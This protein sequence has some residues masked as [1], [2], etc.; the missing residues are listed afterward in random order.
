MSAKTSNEALD[1]P[2]RAVVEY[3]TMNGSIT[4]RECRRLLGVSYDHSVRLL[5]EMCTSGALSRRG[6]AS[7][8]HY[9]L[10]NPR[11]SSK[12]SA[13]LKAKIL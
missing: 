2:I 6:A 1:D 3:V 9:V 12:A 4:N 13:A 10:A 11:L 7:G 5:K 8:T